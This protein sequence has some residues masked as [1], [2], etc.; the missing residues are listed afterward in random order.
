MQHHGYG[1]CLDNS[2]LLLRG[3]L[4]N[5]LFHLT[6]GQGVAIS[7][8]AIIKTVQLRVRVVQEDNGFGMTGPCFQLSLSLHVGRR[9][10][11]CGVE[12][13]IK[14]DGAQRFRIVVGGSRIDDIV[15]RSLLIS[16]GYDAHLTVTFPLLHRRG[17]L[18]PGQC[19]A[20][21]ERGGLLQ[22]GIIGVNSFI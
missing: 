21:A 10:S 11:A 1:R 6:D 12:S 15:V 19:V 9:S 16:L 13:A 18:I 4:R 3:T 17:R 14:N 5:F 22:L 20:A 7:L 8:G 2:S